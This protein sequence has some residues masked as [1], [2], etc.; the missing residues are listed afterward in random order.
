MSV[1]PSPGLSFVTRRYAYFLTGYEVSCTQHS[2][3]SSFV[4]GRIKSVDQ[5][6]MVTIEVFELGPEAHPNLLMP[7]LLRHRDGQIRTVHAS[8]S[9]IPDIITHI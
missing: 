8:V 6:G 5:S 3:L 9:R 4:W 1:E 2:Q 7:V